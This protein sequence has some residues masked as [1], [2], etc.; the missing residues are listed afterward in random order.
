MELIFHKQ[1]VRHL[2]RYHHLQVF[3]LVYIHLRVL[4]EKKK[5]SNDSNVSIR[6]SNILSSPISENNF[7][8]VAYGVYPK[9]IKFFTKVFFFG[10]ILKNFFSSITLSNGYKPVKILANDG[11]VEG[12]AQ[13][14]C[15][16]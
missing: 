15:E 9:S 13:I 12:A 1:S 14:V 2:Q 16:K 7:G 8:M 11:T 5:F 4:Y 6:F 10:S 3:S